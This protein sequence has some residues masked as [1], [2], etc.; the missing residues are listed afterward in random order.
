MHGCARSAGTKKERFLRLLLSLLFPCTGVGGEG[1]CG[2]LGAM[3]PASLLLRLSL[4][5]SLRAVALARWSCRAFGCH[6]AP[7]HP[8]RACPSTQ[9]EG[10]KA[11]QR[12][13]GPEH[14]HRD[15]AHCFQT[16]VRLVRAPLRV[17][18]VISI[19]K[20]SARSRRVEGRSAPG[21]LSMAF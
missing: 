4:S 16:A 3:V 5:L 17:Q 13:A 14:P 18:P 12:P 6:G 10:R 2:N 9:A 11:P 8:G 15:R 21:S 19:G 1:G 20:R 7:G